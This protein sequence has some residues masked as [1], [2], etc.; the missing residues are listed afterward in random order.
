MRLGPFGIALDRPPVGANR[1]IDAAGGLQHV[2]EVVV[3]ARVFRFEGH[4]TL[5]ERCRL[6][7]R[8]QPERDQRARLQRLPMVGLGGENRAVERVCFRQLSGPRVPRRAAHRLADT[9]GREPPALV[10]ARSA[11]ASRHRATPPRTMRDGG[12]ATT[13]PQSPTV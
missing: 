12:D 2:A 7:R 11:I 10:A 9:R 1:G 8:I 5:Q 4:R 6:V 13:R 3:G